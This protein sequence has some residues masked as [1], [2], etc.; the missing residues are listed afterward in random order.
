LKIAV[1]S[2]N[3]ALGFDIAALASAFNGIVGS[4][5]FTGIMATEFQVGG[6]KDAFRFI[7]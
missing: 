6:K 2:A 1:D 7:T 3:E 4:V 5:L